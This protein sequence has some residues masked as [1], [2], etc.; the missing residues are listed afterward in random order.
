LKKTIEVVRKGLL[1]GHSI[2]VI[3]DLADISI[4][5]VKKYISQFEKE[6]K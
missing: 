4:E 3:A 5:E 6:K 1:K 2:E